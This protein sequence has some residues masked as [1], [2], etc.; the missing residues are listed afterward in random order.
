MTETDGLGHNLIK[1]PNVVIKSRRICMCGAHR[2]LHPLRSF[3]NLCIQLVC[4][5]SPIIIQ[6]VM[7]SGRRT[8]LKAQEKWLEKNPQWPET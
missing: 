6:Y 1:M 3:H 8:R 5:P 7:V 4:M 2:E